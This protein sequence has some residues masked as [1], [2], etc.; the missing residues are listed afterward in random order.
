MNE[1]G[2]IKQVIGSAWYD[3][4]NERARQHNRT[5]KRKYKPLHEPFVINPKWG[6]VNGGNV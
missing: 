2:T 4:H 6:K 3:K 5:H 1:L